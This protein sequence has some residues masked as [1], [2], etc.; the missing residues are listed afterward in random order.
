MFL[1]TGPCVTNIHSFFGATLCASTIS[2]GFY[3]PV[4]ITPQL[5]LCEKEEADRILCSDYKRREIFIPFFSIGLIFHLN[6]ALRELAFDQITYKGWQFKEA[7]AHKLI[8]PAA[9]L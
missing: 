7:P 8:K 6:G 1:S 4:V 3:M 2:S 9:L 5:Y